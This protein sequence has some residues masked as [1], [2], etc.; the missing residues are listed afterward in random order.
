MSINSGAVRKGV[1]GAVL[2]MLMLVEPPLLVALTGVIRPIT[3]IVGAL[4]DKKIIDLS[5]L[6]KTPGGTEQV[7]KI[8][9]KLRLSNEILEDTYL[10]IAVRQGTILRR[11][12]EAMHAALSGIPGF[13][14]ALR[15][16]TGNA[17]NKKEGHLDILN[18]LRIARVA[19]EHGFKV[20]E[21]GNN[22]INTDNVNNVKK[23]HSN[24]SRIAHEAPRHGFEVTEVEEELNDGTKRMDTDIDIILRKNGKIF[25]I[26]AKNYDQFN[27]LDMLKLDM[28]TL[29]EYK[30]FHKGESIIPVFTITNRPANPQREALMF[31]EAQKRGVQLLFGTPLEQIEQIKLLE[32]II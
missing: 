12:A 29:V 27:N 17:K 19:Y 31:A 10:R 5:M 4:S 25:A 30:K 24:E 14:T 32:L 23:G 2:C 1:L 6:S 11:E 16:T 8:L 20:M 21:I 9:G 22:S 15:K 28:D 3:K 7:G 26:E 13:R 18:M